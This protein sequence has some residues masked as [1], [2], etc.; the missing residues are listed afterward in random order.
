VNVAGQVTAQRTTRKGE[1]D[2]EEGVA[3]GGG[4]GAGRLRREGASGHEAPRGDAHEEQ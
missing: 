4:T 1:S 2:E 3:G